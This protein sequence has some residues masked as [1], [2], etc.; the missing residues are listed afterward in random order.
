MIV[1]DLETRLSDLVGESCPLR[2]RVECL[3]RNGAILCRSVV[4]PLVGLAAK[5]FISLAVL[6]LTHAHLVRI[7]LRRLRVRRTSAVRATLRTLLE[8]P[9][10]DVVAGAVALTGI[11]RYSHLVTI[12]MEVSDRR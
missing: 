1:F 11:E 12:A 6:A 2:R 3:D 4:K 7:G 8:L 10:R 5:V 9:I